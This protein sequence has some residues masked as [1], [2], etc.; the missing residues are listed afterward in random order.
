MYVLYLLTYL[1][2]NYKL[3]FDGSRRSRGAS[4]VRG[5]AVI[6]VGGGVVALHRP[7]SPFFFGEEGSDEVDLGAA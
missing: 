2:T 3:V 6:I 1:L 4:G 7:R 5:G